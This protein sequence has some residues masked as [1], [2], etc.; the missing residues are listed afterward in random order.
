[1]QTV[2]SK[3]LEI[4]EDYLALPKCSQRA[5]AEQLNTS[6]DKMHEFKKMN[7]H[8]RQFLRH[9][10]PTRQLNLMFLHGNEYWFAVIN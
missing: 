4:L 3:K 1:V 2:L 5:A 6:L 10:Q 9:Q 8:I 7:G